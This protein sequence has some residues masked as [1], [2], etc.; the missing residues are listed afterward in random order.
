MNYKNLITLKSS[1]FREFLN[2][3]ERISGV[4]IWYCNKQCIYVGAS[5][6]CSYRA[7][8]IFW[9]GGDC[10]KPGKKI[11]KFIKKN[12]IKRISIVIIPI[13][14]NNIRNMEQLFYKVCKPI[15]MNHCPLYKE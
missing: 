5:I 14:K 10:G 6:N 2:N 8:R 11:N 4:Y 13:Q 7:T 3:E 1:N 9:S 15:V 12:G